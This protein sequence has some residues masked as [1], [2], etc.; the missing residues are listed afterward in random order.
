MYAMKRMK[1]TVSRNTR[2]ILMI[3]ITLSDEMQRI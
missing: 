2:G 1:K 3:Y